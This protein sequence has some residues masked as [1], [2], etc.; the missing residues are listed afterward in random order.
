MRSIK[1]LCTVLLMIMASS[2][3]HAQFNVKIGYNPILGGFNGVNAL[4]DAYISNDGDVQSGFNDLSFMHGIQLGGRYRIGKLGVELGWESLSSNREALSLN[5]NNEVFTVR[6]YDHDLTT[7]IFALD[8][9][10]RPVGF[11]AALTRTNYSVGR[12]IGNNSIP[13]L[14]ESQ[15]G[16]R[17]QLNLVIQESSRVSFLIRPY[18]QFYLNDFN[19]EPLAED[20]NN[21][22]ASTE[23]LNYFGLSLVFYNG[24]RY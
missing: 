2:I 22:A 12:E 5:P 11:G 23:S 1:A 24:R 18:Y 20:L 8:Q 17:L 3:V 16:L 13:I 19:I 4:Q 7:W 10:L 9:Y 6:E 15:W 21:T 14:A